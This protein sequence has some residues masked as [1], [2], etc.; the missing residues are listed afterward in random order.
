MEEQ[1]AAWMR[2]PGGVPPPEE[3]TRRKRAL[4]EPVASESTEAPGSKLAKVSETTKISPP[5]KKY[6]LIEQYTK[7]VPSLPCL[8]R[9][10][11]LCKPKSPTEEEIQ[12][13]KPNNRQV[14]EDEL[15]LN[16]ARIAAEVL[17]K[18][19]IFDGISPYSD[20][21]RSSYSPRSSFGLS[22]PFAQSMSPPARPTHNYE[23]AYAPDTPDGLGRSMSRTEQ[24]IRM[25]GAHGLAYKPLDF[26]R[27]EK[28]LLARKAREEKE[29]KE[30]FTRS[31]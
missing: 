11:E 26:T 22:R 27:K 12:A 4:E 9:A 1:E 24:R 25:T 30:K 31:E 29:E 19:S 7:A 2:F 14:D 18:G 8:E 23:V 3:G 13:A 6:S 28:E 17:R 20:P 5:A 10:K 15:L 16:A 21:F